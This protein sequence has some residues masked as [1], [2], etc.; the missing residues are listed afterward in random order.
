M[1]INIYIIIAVVICS[2]GLILYLIIQNKKDEK[3]LIETLN[4][5]DVD[6]DKPKNEDD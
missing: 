4:A 5:D 6:E 3:D 2:I 1:E